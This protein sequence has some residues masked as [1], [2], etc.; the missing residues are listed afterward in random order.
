[1]A[2]RWSTEYLQSI[3][4]NE[5]I[6]DQ[7]WNPKYVS[8]RMAKQIRSG[9]FIGSSRFSG[10]GMFA[11][12]ELKKSSVVG[13]F[14][15]PVLNSR[16]FEHADPHFVSYIRWTHPISKNCYSYYFEV[17]SASKLMNG[18]IPPDYLYG[19]SNYPMRANVGLDQTILKIGGRYRPVLV[20]KT[21][22]RI[23]EGQELL[24]DYGV[25]HDSI[26][27]E[28]LRRMQ[29]QPGG[30]AERKFERFLDAQFRLWIIKNGSRRYRTT[31]YNDAFLE[32]FAMDYFND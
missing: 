8:S 28:Y 12:R 19:G 18:G 4:I 20:L 10:R 27:F 5:R 22:H 21:F 16:T 3:D 15:G 31:R 17:T 24:L 2:N 25:L 13:Y 32:S 6:G 7:F 11:N 29:L 26:Y 14:S 23:A 30:Q 1:M 9:S